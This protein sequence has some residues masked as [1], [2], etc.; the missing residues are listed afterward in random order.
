MFWAAVEGGREAP[1]LAHPHGGPSTEEGA[2]GSGFFLAFYELV[3]SS[4]D[5][6]PSSPSKP[7]PRL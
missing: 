3:K 6:T 1:S 2:L 4:F 7:N 5:E